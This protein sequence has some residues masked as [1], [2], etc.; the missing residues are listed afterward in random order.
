MNLTFCKLLMMCVC[1]AS[2]A[3]GKLAQRMTT[4][5]EEPGR[6]NDDDS[7]SEPESAPN[8]ELSTPRSYVCLSPF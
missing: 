7:H 4:L 5:H 1:A 2:P 8:D 6:R 3:S